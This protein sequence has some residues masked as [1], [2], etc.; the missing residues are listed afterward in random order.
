MRM[1]DKVGGSICYKIFSIMHHQGTKHANAYICIELQPSGR[2]N[3]KNKLWQ[4]SRYMSFAI[5]ELRVL[6]LN[7]KDGELT[8]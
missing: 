7:G 1:G 3:E 8:I 4:D 2:A 6:C 5:Y